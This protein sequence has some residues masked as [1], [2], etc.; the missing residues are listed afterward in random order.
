V[1]LALNAETAP[2]LATLAGVDK[3]TLTSIAEKLA[4]GETMT[5]PE[6]NT[7]GRFDV[8]LATFIDRAY[9]KADQRYRTTAKC[10]AC[11][12]AIALAEAAAYFLRMLD[13]NGHINGYNFGLAFVVG[14]IA[15]PLAPVAKDLATA[16]TTA[17]K[18]VQTVKR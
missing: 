9:Q 18:A 2:D 5:Q 11:L 16:L 1:K 10:A 6:M 3:A 17:S 13:T 14:L 12:V 8:L 7:Y 15:T 4:N